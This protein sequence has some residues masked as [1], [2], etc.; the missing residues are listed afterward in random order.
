MSEEEKKKKAGKVW[1][2][3]DFIKAWQ[4]NSGTTDWDTFAAAMQKARVA[5]GCEPYAKGFAGLSIQLGKQK[6]A[7]NKAGFAAPKYPE[8]PKKEAKKAVSIEEDAAALG[9]GAYVP[10]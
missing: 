4:S 3:R 1:V 7:L 10:E 2:R 9:L 8:K 6:K 5:A